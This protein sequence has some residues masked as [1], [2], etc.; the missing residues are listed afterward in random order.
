VKSRPQ[1]SSC[2]GAREAPTYVLLG[3]RTQKPQSFLGRTIC[4]FPGAVAVEDAGGVAA[5]IVFSGKLRRSGGPIS[6]SRGRRSGSGSKLRAN[7]VKFRKGL[8]RTDLPQ[9]R[10]IVLP[11]KV[12]RLLRESWKHSLIV[13]PGNLYRLGREALSSR[14]GTNVVLRGKL[15]RLLRE[16]ISSSPGKRIVLSGKSGRC[17]CWKSAFSSRWL[18]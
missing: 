10:Y 18:R 5:N 12:Y 1:P 4:T 16:V 11:G 3:Q 9:A 7:I 17:F 8:R 6:S 15:Y 14:P 13:L 2:E